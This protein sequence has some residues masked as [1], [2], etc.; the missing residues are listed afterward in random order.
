MNCF[1]S[2]VCLSLCLSVSTRPPL[3]PSPHA[4]VLAVCHSHVTDQSP[5]QG[6]RLWKPAVPPSRSL[7]WHPNCCRTLTFW[8]FFSVLYFSTFLSL[9]LFFFFFGYYL[10]HAKMLI[11]LKESIWT[12][13]LIVYPQILDDQ[14][15]FWM[16]EKINIRFVACS[17]YYVWKNLYLYDLYSFIEYNWNFLTIM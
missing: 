17:P 4:W 13:C 1:L 8:Y 12:I 3:S 7:H 16:N 11:S 14:L 5:P 15:N 2:L 6:A 9:S 10:S